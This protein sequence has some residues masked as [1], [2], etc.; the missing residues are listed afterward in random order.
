MFVDYYKI[1]EIEKN[2]TQQEIKTAFRK[3][4][5]KWH[6]DK[7][8]NID[9]NEKMQL[10]N[11][12]YLIL[13][14]EEARYHYDIEYT[15]FYDFYNSRKEQKS[16]SDF[17]KKEKQKVYEE[18]NFEDETLK[19]WMQNAKK[20][21]IDLARQTIR[22]MGELSLKATKEAGSK[23]LETFIYYAIAGIIIMLLLKACN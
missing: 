7:N 4:A 11:E 18:Y 13:K 15:K 20:Q 21:A 14:D 10:I 16:G 19:K 9:V 5:I 23:M 12:A 8:P 3:Q 22:E 6:P 17:S 2:S 1:L